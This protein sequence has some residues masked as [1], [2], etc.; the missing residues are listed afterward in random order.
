MGIYLGQHPSERLFTDRFCVTSSYFKFFTAK[1]SCHKQ[2]GGLRAASMDAA[3][4]AQAQLMEPAAAY[5]SSI[6]TA[7]CDVTYDVNG[8]SLHSKMNSDG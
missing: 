6:D 3:A 2:Y 7:G 5:S 4:A 1:V 8:V